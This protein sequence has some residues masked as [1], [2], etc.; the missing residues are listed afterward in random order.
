MNPASE[1]VLSIA[2]SWLRPSGAIHGLG[3][4]EIREC[5]NAANIGCAACDIL[6]A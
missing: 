4:G 1:N 3:D 5:R 2:E 6:P